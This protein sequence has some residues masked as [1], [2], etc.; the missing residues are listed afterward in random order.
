MKPLTLPNEI[1]LTNELWEKIQNAANIFSSRQIGKSGE[2]GG[3]QVEHLH[4]V[5]FVY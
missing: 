4:W 5:Y 1:P 3:C 2:V